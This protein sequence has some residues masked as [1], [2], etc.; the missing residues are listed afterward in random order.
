MLQTFQ[1]PSVQYPLTS[2]F[3][4]Q[5]TTKS[6]LNSMNKSNRDRYISYNHAYFNTNKSYEKF[7]RK[8]DEIF[9]FT[10]DDFWIEAYQELEND[11]I[12]CS[13]ENIVK[14]YQKKLEEN[15]RAP[16]FNTEIRWVTKR[17]QYQNIDGSNSLLDVIK[18]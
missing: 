17:D 7:N 10:D 2:N 13:S 12:A 4:S 18:E 14:L 16:S 6:T 8:K 11:G 1:K 15:F 3:F 5:T 9:T